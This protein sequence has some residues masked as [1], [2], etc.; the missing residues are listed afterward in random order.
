MPK[1]VLWI[2]ADIADEEESSRKWNETAS[3]DQQ[4]KKRRSGWSIDS[5]HE[6]LVYSSVQSAC[7][8]QQRQWRNRPE[9]HGSQ[10]ENSKYSIATPYCIALARWP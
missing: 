9:A 10:L 6:S 1:F 2:R 8:K 5:E 3:E 7:P 4:R